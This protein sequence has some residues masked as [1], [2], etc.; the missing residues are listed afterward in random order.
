MLIAIALLGLIL[1][2]AAQVWRRGIERR[3]FDR[4]H[5]IAPAADA[6]GPLR[7]L[8]PTLADEPSQQLRA[9]KR[10]ANIAGILGL[11]ISGVAVFLIAV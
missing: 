1:F 4:W 9:Q 11:A 10:W 3:L 6:A 7:Q 5:E 8:D 2:V